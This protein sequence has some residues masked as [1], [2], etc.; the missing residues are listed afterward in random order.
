MV[1]VLDGLEK[2]YKWAGDP[3]SARD[4]AGYRGIKVDIEGLKRKWSEM[5]CK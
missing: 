1:M 2:V 4:I 5:A 3:E